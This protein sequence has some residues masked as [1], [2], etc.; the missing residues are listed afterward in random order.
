MHGSLS[1]P[2]VSPTY[3]TN[4]RIYKR[5]YARFGAAPRIPVFIANFHLA[6]V[7]NQIRPMNILRLLHN[8]FTAFPNGSKTNKKAL[9]P[10]EFESRP[11][12]RE[13]VFIVFIAI[14]S[15]SASLP[16]RLL[17]TV[18]TFFRESFHPGRR[19]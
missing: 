5:G 12:K 8:V 13:T 9:F 3:N 11:I 4:I 17:F 14:S 2:I 16:C 1:T 19:Q 6:F 10:P 15:G 18:M 7:Q